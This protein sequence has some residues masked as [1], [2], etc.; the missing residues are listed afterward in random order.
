[1]ICCIQQLTKARKAVDVDRIWFPGELEEYRKE[2]SCGI[3]RLDQ[4][5]WESI[6]EIGDSLNVE[7]N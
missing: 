5:A 7:Y 1:M 6:K 4:E 2:A 3:V